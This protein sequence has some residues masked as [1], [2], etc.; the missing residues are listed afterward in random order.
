MK[1]QNK[2]GKPYS[3]GT[4]RTARKPNSKFVKAGHKKVR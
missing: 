1:Q 2:Y 4:Y 3:H